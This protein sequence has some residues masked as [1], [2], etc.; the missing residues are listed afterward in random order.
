M[1]DKEKV[2]T[3]LECCRMNGNGCKRC[4]YNKDCDEMPDY[5]NAQL[6]SDALELLNKQTQW[7]SVKD[8]LPEMHMTYRY[9]GDPPEEVPSGIC[10]SKIVQ[11]A[12]LCKESG[13]P[14]YFIERGYLR[15][16]EWWECN[17]FYESQIPFEVTH[18]MPLPEPPEVK[19]ND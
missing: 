15:D 4:P 2:L 7:I 19:Q 3:G 9:D 10:K 17:G 14:E 16:G 11:I 6:C 13:E 8:K 12:V 18:W 1:I 5:G